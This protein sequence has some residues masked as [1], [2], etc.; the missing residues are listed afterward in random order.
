MIDKNKIIELNQKELTCQEIKNLLGGSLTTIRKY[1]KENGFQ[2][3]SKITR[4]NND[5]LHHI[6]IL[7]NKGYTNSEIAEK[8][9][10]SKTTT[11]KY[12]Y[13]LNKDTNSSKNKRIINKYIEL[14]KTQEEILYGSLLGDM[15]ISKTKN[16]YRPSISHGGQQ[17]L[18][19]DYKCKEFKNLLGKIN[20]SKRFNK[21]TKKYYNKYS[22]KFLA[23]QVYEKFYNSLYKNGIKSVT[24][25]WLDKITPLGLAIWFM[26][27]GSNCGTI[28][29]NCFTK[30][31]C[32]LI[33]KLLKSKYNIETT[34]QKQRKEN[35]QYVI[36]IKTNSR[37]L[38]YNTIIKYVIP[39]MLYKLKNWNP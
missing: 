38:F 16:L 34:L 37:K 17:E 1:I 7:L 35:I 29:T 32:F 3:N 28:A 6:D 8:L 23:N 15:S 30:E 27:D 25:E 21:R 9:K 39:S 20:K 22:V 4:L 26:D 5:V 13:I 19:F 33:Q 31:E 12:T 14:I 18:Y 10:M 2:T 24:Q 11:R 36:Y